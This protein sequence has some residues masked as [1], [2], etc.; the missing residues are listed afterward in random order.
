[1]LGENIRKYRKLNNM[2]Q[3]ELSE[4]LGVTRQSVSLWENDQTQ[5]SLDNI[6]ALSK[7]FGVSTDDL[8]TGD[9]DEIA[10]VTEAVEAAP[11]KGLTK[12]KKVIIIAA[13]AVLAL[14][15]AAAIIYA[16]TSPNKTGDSPEVIDTGTTGTSET[17]SETADTTETSVPE[18][19]VTTKKEKKK[20][21]SETKKPTETSATSVSATVQTPAVTQIPVVPPVTS[22]TTT[23]ATTTAATTPKATQPPVTTAAT[24]KATTA[25]VE[26]PKDFYAYFKDFVVTKGKLNGD[27]CSYVNSSD[28]YGGYASE[29]FI[30]YY[31][32]DTD[33][34]EFCLHS[35][36]N[37]TYSI[38]FY[39]KIPKT[40][41]GVYDYIVSYYYRD[42]GYNYCE[43][44]GTINAAEFTS[45]YPLTCSSYTGPSNVQNDF[46]E[47][48]REGMCDT[49]RCLKNFLEVEHTPY[50]FTDL[51]FKKF[52]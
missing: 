43:A 16:L 15:I 38:A 10:P 31:W 35:V 19:T 1:M 13:A 33:T 4:K 22:V 50:K 14:L 12:K 30:L 45:S 37:E 2:S 51:G 39:L 11:E 3:D 34:V 5:P 48:A 26:A 17:V 28:K 6:V 18:T 36:I 21:E 46:M 27:Y 41:N 44:K 49:L 40:Y 52:S 8:L 7:L 32:G 9:S 29:N 23:A 24:T 42:T 20:S 25:P 47:M